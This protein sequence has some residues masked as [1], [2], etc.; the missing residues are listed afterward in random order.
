MNTYSFLLFCWWF[1]SFCFNWLTNLLRFFTT[2]CTHSR[3]YVF[4]KSL[5]FKAFL[6]LWYIKPFSLYCIVHC[7]LG[8]SHS[9]LT[10]SNCLWSLLCCVTQNTIT[11]FFLLTCIALLKLNT[12]SCPK[13]VLNYLINRCWWTISLSKSETVVRKLIK[14]LNQY[15]KRNSGIILSSELILFLRCD[16]TLL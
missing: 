3:I 2:F 10:Q 15:S 14:L 13:L 1:S 6:F 5:K 7:N 16:R 11:Y 8:V 12:C 4:C 9:N